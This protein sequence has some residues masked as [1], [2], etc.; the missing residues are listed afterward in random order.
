MKWLR[1]NFW[2]ILMLLASV[3]ATMQF[4]SENTPDTISS[5]THLSPILTILGAIS[6]RKI[7]GWTM[8][9]CIPLLV[10]AFFKGRAFCW[11]VCPVGLITE[12][13]G[14][15]N[16]HGRTLINHVPVLNKIILLVITATAIC[17][18]PL[19]IWL[20][21]FCLF[22][23]FLAS[24]HAPLT[25][26]SC[27]IGLPFASVLITS[28]FAPNI[29]CHR[30]CPLGVLQETI[31]TLNPFKRKTRHS[32]EAPNS[33]LSSVTRRTLLCAVPSAVAGIAASRLLRS[34][35]RKTIRPPGA[36]LN[37]INALCARCGNCMQACPYQLIK[38][39]IGESGIDGLLT[40]SIKFRSKDINQEQY[41]F[42]DCVKCS[43]VCPTGA[44]RPITPET[45]AATPIGVAVVNRKKCIAWEKN[46][47]CAV[48]DEYCPFKAVKLIKR[49]DVM[50]PVV[51]VDKCRGCGACESACPAEPIAI[52]VQPI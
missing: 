37:K 18:Y 36:D 39:D 4:V 21:P 48:C 17:G 9:I 23:G 34:N 47:Y 35:G 12:T 24:L 43:Q 30:L 7:L 38:P 52:I 32:T 31:F 3:S 25:I 15:L 28:V 50:C 13:I 51:E 5:L 49:G 14:K 29:W 19:F 2:R 16:P 20:D 11:K 10:S 22:N 41:C 8:L 26:V 27:S 1:R 33:M 44:L 46:E 45:K 40:P 6:A 42:H